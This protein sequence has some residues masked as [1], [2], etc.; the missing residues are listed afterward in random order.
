MNMIQ[1]DSEVVTAEAFAALIDMMYTSTLMLGESNVMDVLLAASHL[2]LNAVVKAC[3]HYLTTRTLPMS[4][5]GST[6]NE[7]AQ[8]EQQAASSRLQRSFLLQQLGLS[9]VSSA[10]GGQNGA[11]E[12]N[13]IR[14]GGAGVVEQRASFP[15]RRFHKR[16]PSAA[17]DR[18]RQR[19]RPSVTAKESMM[20]GD[21]GGV[22]VDTGA[23]AR[24]FFSTDS[25][26]LGNGPKLD[27][28]LGSISS[29]D[30]QDDSTMMFEQ[31]YGTQE[32]AQLP[33]QSDGGNNTGM[34]RNDQ[35]AD[36]GS[37][38]G[39]VPPEDAGKDVGVQDEKEED[40]E[41]HMRVVVK[42]E[43]LSS[44]E[45]QDE[46]SD[47]TSQ[48]EGS[49]QVEHGA[50]KIELSPE[51]SD[52][53]FSDLQSTTDRAGDIHLLDAPGGGGNSRGGG[54]TS[55]GNLDDKQPFSIS[56][57]LSKG[58][59]AG[60][61]YSQGIKD[62]LAN[63]TSGECRMEGDTAYLI[64]PESVNGHS[65]H[66]HHHRH[67]HQHLS[68]DSNPFS[69]SSDAHFLRPMQ[70]AMG[71]GYRG[72]DQFSLDFQGS[73]LGLHSFS[74][75]TKGVEGGGG[76]MPANMGFPGYRRIAP[77]MQVMGASMRMDGT[78]LQD[79]SSS[80]SSFGGV[81]GGSSSNMLL[82]RAASSG[83]DGGQ[84]VVAPPQLTRASA[85]VLSK[86]K[87]ALS[88]HNVL[89]VEGARK[90]A[91]K[92]CCKTF[93]T[94]TDCK[95]HIRVHTGEKPY[96][97]LK[98]GKRFSQSSHLYKHSKTTCLRW[99]NSNLPNTLL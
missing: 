17:E 4:P 87:K 77:K 97:C 95:K 34:S 61:S 96:A 53:S 73:S 99:Q 3:K 78:Q 81:V 46:V 45:P 50:D 9:L 80:S 62:N 14:G 16:K 82:N 54:P 48:A 88:E 20:M 13:P 6:N 28:G 29:V 42:S 22:V 43:P 35:A 58:R 79:A 63:T 68:E 15:I 64:S 76:G 31:P 67:N 85:D 41:Q 69:D 33:S 21:V 90:Y 52:R 49:D 30:N 56:S 92:I 75:S 39:Q 93:L 2:H 74:R 84:Q 19:L 71:H 26:K 5:P 65:H 89:V 83:Y 40:E 32:D 11:D 59:A 55:N 70:D 36:D 25:H 60:G 37:F 23:N 51:S 1:L 38:Q 27:G 94:L 8:Q 66:H 44:P 18:S 86:C 24:E 10:L 12:T 57:F 47:V 7:R 91:C 98:C 72:G